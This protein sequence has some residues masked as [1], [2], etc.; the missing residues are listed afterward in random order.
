VSSTGA[1]QGAPS[2]SI[3][4]LQPLRRTSPPDEDGALRVV[5]LLR[6]FRWCRSDLLVA[7]PP[8]VL[9]PLGASD[10]SVPAPRV[11]GGTDPLASLNSP[12]ASVA[13]ANAVD[14]VRTSELARTA[15]TGFV[16]PPADKSQESTNPGLPRP[17][18][19]ALRVSHPLCGLLLLRPLGLVSYRNAHGVVPSEYDHRARQQTLSGRLTSRAVTNAGEPTTAR[20]RRLELTRRLRHRRSDTQ[21]LSWV[22]A[23]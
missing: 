7:A 10:A 5:L 1:P 21:S 17:V 3:E 2:R 22:L 12:S 16:A 6:V 14:P 13:L 23:L 9:R 15:P 19:S 20:L 18:R 4:N 11:N 8:L